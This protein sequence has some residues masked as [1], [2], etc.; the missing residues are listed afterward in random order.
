M[1]RQEKITVDWGGGITVEYNINDIMVTDTDIGISK[2]TLPIPE[3][4]MHFFK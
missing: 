1:L 2:W 4:S 3:L